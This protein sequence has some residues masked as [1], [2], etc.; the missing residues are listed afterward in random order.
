MIGKNAT[1]FWQPVDAATVVSW[2]IDRTPPTIS[3]FNYPSGT[4]SATDAAIRVGGF[5]V[6]YYR[7]RMGVIERIQT[8]QNGIT[9]IFPIN[10][11]TEKNWGVELSLNQ[12]IGETFSFN[13]NANLFRANTKGSYRDEDLSSHTSAFR[14]RGE[15]N[16]EFLDHWETEASFYYRGPRNTTQGRTEGFASMNWSLARELF[17]GDASISLDVR[18]VFNSEERTFIVDNK[19][20]YSKNTFRWSTR[21][22]EL[23]ITYNF[24][25]DNQQ[26]RRDGGRRGGR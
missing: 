4:V 11:A 23:N 20:L 1:G 24:G 7:Y 9:R 21:S 6:V 18:D 17:D 13:G 14:G 8:A 2:T 26:N 16:W 22:V 12:D 15:L 25:Q 10:L 19:Y 3:L 5:D